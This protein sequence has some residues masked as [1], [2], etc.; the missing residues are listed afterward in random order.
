MTI[1]RRQIVIGLGLVTTTLWACTPSKGDG[2][3]AT[4]EKA[5][6]QL[7]GVLGA[8]AS[9]ALPPLAASESASGEMLAAVS[10]TTDSVIKT[11]GS[12]KGSAAFKEV[13]LAVPKGALSGSG[14]L[15]IAEGSSLA[16]PILAEALGIAEV[17][18]AS[19]TVI[20]N[21]SAV[22][23]VNP[24]TIALPTGV[25]LS[26]DGGLLQVVAIIPGPGNSQ[27]LNVLP[28]ENVKVTDS[29]VYAEIT[30]FGAYQAVKMSSQ[31]TT[32]SAPTTLAPV[33][34]PGGGATTTEIGAALLLAG[35]E[36]L[37]TR[38]ISPHP[39][40]N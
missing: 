29:A 26:L 16:S 19:P 36:V 25:S 31:P 8:P 34:S 40:M 12:T 6:A 1:S 17:A 32:T 5:S 33:K 18:Q 28:A 27:T 9:M 20:I 15:T 39:L 2:V 35:P 21:A 38:L 23:I 13:A 10:A 30:Q 7:P 14:T 37:P 24:L 22:S 11:A 3:M 4:A